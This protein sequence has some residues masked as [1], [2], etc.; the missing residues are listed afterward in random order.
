MSYFYGIETVLFWTVPLLT[1][2]W[3][4]IQGYLEMLC[5]QN[6]WHS[7]TSMLHCQHCDAFIVKVV[8]RFLPNTPDPF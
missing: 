4:L 6:L 3:N 5:P 1:G 7:T 8:A 2:S